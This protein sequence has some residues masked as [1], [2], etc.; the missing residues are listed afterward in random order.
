MQLPGRSIQAPPRGY[1]APTFD[2][3][4]GVHRIRI[5]E[6]ATGVTQVRDFVFPEPLDDGEMATH[7]E[8][9]A[10]ERALGVGDLTGRTFVF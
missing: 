5:R 7:V 1:D 8:V 3:P 2:V 6:R 4:P 10:Q 9:W